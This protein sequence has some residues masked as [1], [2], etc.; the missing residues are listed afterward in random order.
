MAQTRGRFLEGES[1]EC[2]LQLDKESE[3]DR[4]IDEEARRLNSGHWVYGG[5]TNGSRDCRGGGGEGRKKEEV[6]ISILDRLSGSRIM[7]NQR[8]SHP[9]PWNP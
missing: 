9:N 1:A 2:H 5:A 3:E 8:C 7:A 6:L 4:R